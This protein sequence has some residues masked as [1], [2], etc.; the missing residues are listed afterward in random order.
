MAEQY[1]LLKVDKKGKE[2]ASSKAAG[3]A[4]CLGEG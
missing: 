3:Y 1:E 4:L 2:W